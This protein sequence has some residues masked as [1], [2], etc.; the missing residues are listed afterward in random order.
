MNS[1]SSI[2]PSVVINL[3]ALSH[4][5]NLVIG[6]EGQGIGFYNDL[7]ILFATKVDEKQGEIVCDSLNQNTQ[8][9]RGKIT[10]FIEKY[11]SFNPRINKLGDYFKK[12]DEG[13]YFFLIPST[14]EVPF[15]VYENLFNYLVSLRDGV[16]YETVIEQTSSLFSDLRELYD[17][18]AYGNIPVSIGES[19]K[20]KRV[21]RFCGKDASKTTFKTKAHTIS[22]SLG[23]NLIVTNDECDICNNKFG[24]DVEG[25]FAEYVGVFR[26]IMGMRGYNGIPHIKGDNFDI[27][28][29]NGQ[30]KLNYI[31]SSEEEENMPIENMHLPLHSKQK[32]RLQNVYRSIVKYALSVLDASEMS[33]FT[34]TIE[35]IF[36]KKRIDKLPKVA[37]LE[38]PSF[39]NQQPQIIVYRRKKDDKRLPYLVVEFHFAH[40]VFVAIV[41]KTDM[42]DV[43]FMNGN[44]YLHFW[45][46]FKHFSSNTGWQF[47]DFSSDIDDTFTTNLNIVQRTK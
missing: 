33:H 32:I 21:C 37:M 38:V 2:I 26:S 43:D 35:W 5:S 15:D 16:S 39:Y 46:T 41:P 27:K 29:E 14:R 3:I 13:E 19:D 10:G 44:E 18:K 17:M 42:D 28:Q 40:F 45:K 47:K 34:D 12:L 30:V 7:M 6:L 23:N 9:L 36:Q 24:K 1:S 31:A 11:K 25:D 8:E 22:K 4:S 20:T